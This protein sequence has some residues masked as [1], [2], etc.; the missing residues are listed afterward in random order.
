[1]NWNRWM[2][3][4][5]RWLSVV[6]TLVV[7]AN[8]VIVARGKYQTWEGLAAVFLLG[9]MLVTGLYLLALPWAAK[10]R[11]RRPHGAGLTGE[12]AAG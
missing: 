11:G 10:W 8:G 2:R 7:I 1:M 6:F 9:L 12:R 5:H 3:Q 4:I